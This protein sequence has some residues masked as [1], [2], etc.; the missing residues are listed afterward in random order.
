MVYLILAVDAVY[1]GLCHESMNAFDCHMP[2]Y[3]HTDT[4]VAAIDP[5]LQ[6][7]SRTS[8]PALRTNLVSGKPLYWPPLL[9][10]DYNYPRHLNFITLLYTGCLAP[11]SRRIHT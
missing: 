2:I 4:L 10:T 6:Y 11:R 3:T 7:L 8:H 5:W 1:K 9:H